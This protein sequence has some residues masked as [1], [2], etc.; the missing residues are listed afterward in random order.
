[1]IRRNATLRICRDEWQCVRAFQPTIDV[2]VGASDD[3]GHLYLHV[4]LF[5]FLSLVRFPSSSSSFSPAAIAAV[6]TAYCCFII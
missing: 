1:M 3:V 4:L 2:G 5:F 6:A